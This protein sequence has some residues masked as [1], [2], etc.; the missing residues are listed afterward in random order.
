[1]I[2]KI[3]P[4]RLAVLNESVAKKE[5]DPSRGISSTAK[6]SP[7][8]LTGKLIE[9]VWP[10]RCFGCAAVVWNNRSNWSGSIGAFGWQQRREGSFGAC[11]LSMLPTLENLGGSAER[12]YVRVWVVMYF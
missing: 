5:D 3:V 9:M 11:S 7:C 10:T 4:F 12:V 8:G 6:N 1:M 2:A